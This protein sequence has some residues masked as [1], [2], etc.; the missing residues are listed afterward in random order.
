MKI[1]VLIT[2]L[3]LSISSCSRVVLNGRV[4]QTKEIAQDSTLTYNKALSWC[5]HAYSYGS[6][7]TIPSIGQIIC[8]GGIGNVY[9]EKGSQSYEYNITVDVR[10]NKVVVT[11][12]DFYLSFS[13]YDNDCAAVKKSFMVGLDA[14]TDSLYKATIKNNW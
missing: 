13:S 9:I 3:L 10:Q 11:Y 14:I 1:Y 8:K 4:T 5:A 6:L 12:D 7:Y 2:V